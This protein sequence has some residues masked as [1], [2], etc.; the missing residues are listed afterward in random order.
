MPCLKVALYLIIGLV[1]GFACVTAV[2]HGGQLHVDVLWGPASPPGTGHSFCE[3]PCCDALVSCH[4][5][6]P[7]THPHSNLCCSTGIKTRWLTT[8]PKFVLMSKPSPYSCLYCY[9]AKMF[10]P[11]FFSHSFIHYFS[12]SIRYC[13]FIA[14][15]SPYPKARVIN[16]W[17]LGH[18]WPL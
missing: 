18:M 7:A 12:P 9:D 14:S 3:G 4:R 5:L 11:M 10:R 8:V 6:G 15:V 2:P 13:L 16:V 17:S 1:P